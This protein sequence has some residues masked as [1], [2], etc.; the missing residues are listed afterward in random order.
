MQQFYIKKSQKQPPAPPKNFCRWRLFCRWRAYNKNM[1]LHAETLPFPPERPPEYLPLANEPRFNAARHLALQKP[2]RKIL[3][4]DLGYDEQTIA[5]C[6]SPVAVSSAFRVFSDEGLAV[7]QELCARMKSNRNVSAGT[8]NNRLGSYIRGAGYRSQFVRDFCECPEWLAFVSKVAQ[9]PLARHSVPAVACGINYAPEDIS[10]A[11]DTWH[12]DSVAFD[13][14]ILLNDPAT[15]VGGE[16]QFFM[17]RKEEGEEILGGGGE[18]GSQAELPADRVHT[19]DFVSAGWGFLQQGNRVFHRACRLREPGDRVTMVPSFVA[20][21]K[22][23]EADTTNVDAMS[24]WSDPGLPTEL[25][26][27]AAWQGARRLARA[28][29]SL[30]LSAPPQQLADSLSHAVGEVNR[31]VELLRAGGK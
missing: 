31:Y 22:A 14:V 15:F 29:D 10:R 26:R 16:F 24:K 8:G 28:V 18:A 20:T 25:A 7:M 11:V 13:S 3:L 30:P 21:D 19:M 6:P 17:G 9:T 23:G 27:H 2:E 12:I 5:Q 4:A 1:T